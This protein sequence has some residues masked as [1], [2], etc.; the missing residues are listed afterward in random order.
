MANSST[1]L[2]KAGQEK[3]R[4]VY[5]LLMKSKDQIKVALPRHLTPDRFLRVILTSI[6]KNPLLLECE[7]KSLLAAVMQS[8]QLGLEPDGILGHAYLIPYRNK[9]HNRYEAQLQI[10]YRGFIELARRSGRVQSIQAHVVYE[11]DE[12]QIAYGLDEKLHHVPAR[13]DRGAPIGVY[14][15]AR[16][17]DGSYH[18]EFLWKEDVE[19]IRKKSQVP[20]SEAWQE[21]WEEMWKKTAIRRLAKYLPLAPEL[22]RAAALDEYAEQGLQTEYIDI[23]PVP[24]P[25]EEP[26][27]PQQEAQPA[28]QAFE[29]DRETVNARIAEIKAIIAN[30]KKQEGNE[31][32]A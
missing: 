21:F 12:F 9:K 28:P 3:A 26:D 20:D 10:G 18:F 15:I 25:V 6:R 16:F 2:A 29:P 14:A 5:N 22:S 17:T 11:K 27:R 19:R 24:E 7:E 32:E 30:K 13:G 23:E 31:N 1:G 4:N 8:A